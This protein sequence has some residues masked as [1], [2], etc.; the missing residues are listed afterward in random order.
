EK[1]VGQMKAV[2]KPKGQ[3]GI[4]FTQMMKPEDSKEL[5]LPEKTKLAQVLKKHNLNF[6][7]WNFTKNEHRIWQKCKELAEELKSE[8]E[9]ENFIIY[10]PPDRLL[11]FTHLYCYVNPPQKLADS[12]LP[13]LD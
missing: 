4:F 10:T 9:A 2:L 1:T 8:F 11:N 7:T 3:M 12:L 6:Q 5:L 13:K